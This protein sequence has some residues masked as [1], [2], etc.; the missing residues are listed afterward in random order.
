M[1]NVF[2]L[3]L[4]LVSLSFGCAV[5][6]GAAFADTAEIRNVHVG[7]DGERTRVVIDANQD[8]DFKQLALSTGGIR[9]VLDFDRLTWAI[10]N[11]AAHQGEGFGAGDIQRFRFAHNSQ[12]TSRLVFDL[13]RPLLLE[14]SFTITPPP[15]GDLYR[16]VL[17]FHETDLETFKKVRPLGLAARPSFDDLKDVN[18]SEIISQPAQAKKTKHVVV[19]D[20]GHGGRDPGAIGIRKTNE[21]DINLK[22]A[23]LLRDDLLATGKY[24]V[25][26]TR[27]RDVYI[28]HDG[29]IEIARA[30][31][32]DIFISIHADAAGNR[33][34]SGASVYTLSSA[35]D[36]R[37]E[38]MIDEKGWSIPLEVEP[39]GQAAKD[40]LEDLV[41][42]ETLTKSAQFADILIPELES[43]GPILRNT[44]RQGNLYVLLAPDVPAVLLEIGFLTNPNDENRMLSPTGLSDAMSAVKRS[45]D[46]Y[47]DR[48][49]KIMAAFE[50]N[51][52]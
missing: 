23:I 28:D 22:A 49:E 35:G 41:A 29:R 10:P 4:F 43:A 18:V 9:Y 44:H 45:I 12:S 24:E 39:S 33:A 50:T 26:M 15:G 6:T 36:A 31:M 27:D 30:A 47:F 8:L 14:S 48:E 7:F 52:G 37:V 21:K 42:R 38:E 16:I 3:V 5:S 25:V 46:A 40:I 51:A 19:I 20:A 17:D 1:K 13:E 11:L 2:S 34:V 32:A